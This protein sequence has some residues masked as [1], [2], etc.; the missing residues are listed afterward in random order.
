MWLTSLKCLLLN[1]LYNGF[2]LTHRFMMSYWHD[3]DSLQS[4][5]LW[6]YNLNNT[7]DS[8]PTART[9]STCL[10]SCLFHLGSK[11][12]LPNRPKI[13]DCL[14]VYLWFAYRISF[15]VIYCKWFCDSLREQISKKKM[16]LKD[17][18]NRWWLRCTPHKKFMACGR[19]FPTQIS[20]KSNRLLFV[21]RHHFC[22]R[23]H[24]QSVIFVQ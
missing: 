10:T 1:Y 7:L 18:R 17:E 14:A 21:F 24:T 15:F 13:P 3:V 5:Q 6:N 12:P 16:L 4:K 20:T 2:S 23:V 8:I 19:N 11:W 9:F 22:H